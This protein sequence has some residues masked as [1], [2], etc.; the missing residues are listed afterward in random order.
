MLERG[1]LCINTSSSPSQTDRSVTV[2]SSPEREFFTSVQQFRAQ[3][4][5]VSEP[6]RMYNLW[7]ATSDGELGS[8]RA[9]LARGEDVNIIGR[10]LGEY[11]PL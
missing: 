9:A 2:A 7:D 1:N 6:I 5:I 11:T 8:V 10:G 4:L 3:I